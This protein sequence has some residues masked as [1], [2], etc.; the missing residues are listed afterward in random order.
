[1]SWWVIVL[2][3]IVIFVLLY[4]AGRLVSWEG[5][6]GSQV[7]RGTG[8]DAYREDSEGHRAPK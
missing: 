4:L 3:V 1:M 5:K 2:A 6:M 7:F 8:V